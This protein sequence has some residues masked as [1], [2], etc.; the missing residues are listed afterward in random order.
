LISSGTSSSESAFYDASVTGDDVFFVTTGKLS[1]ADYDKGYDVYDAHVCTGVAPCVS[2]SVGSPVCS[3]GD[4]CKGAPSLQPE[5]FGP[6]PSATFSGVGNVTPPGVVRPRSLTNA[7]RLSRALKACR[8]K[9][10]K[11]QRGVCERRARKRYRVK[12]ARK[13]ASGRG[14]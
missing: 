13:T 1:G 3:S 6:A 9:S 8:K 5:I 2:E 11:R 7:E 12:R 4:S 14:R 10:G